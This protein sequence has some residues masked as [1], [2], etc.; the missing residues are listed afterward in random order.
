M[1]VL[2][3]YL[4]EIFSEIFFAQIA[5]LHRSCIVIGISPA[6]LLHPSLNTKKC[7]FHNKFRVEEKLEHVFKT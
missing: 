6:M 7:T 2:F 5:Y 3:R 1:L 4:P